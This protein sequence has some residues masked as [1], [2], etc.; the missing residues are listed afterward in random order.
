MLPD[1]PVRNYQS[2]RRFTTSDGNYSDVVEQTTRRVGTAA[3]I[4]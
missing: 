1:F 3:Q 4:E 2:R